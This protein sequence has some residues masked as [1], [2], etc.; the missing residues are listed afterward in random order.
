M[1][2]MIECL[3]A[4]TKAWVQNKQRKIKTKTFR[5]RQSG[6]TWSF[7]KTINYQVI[8]AFCSALLEWSRQHPAPAQGIIFLLHIEERRKVH[9]PY[10][11]KDIFQELCLLLLPLFLICHVVTYKLI[12]QWKIENDWRPF[13][14]TLW[15]LPSQK[16]GCY[17]YVQI[18]LVD[19][20]NEKRL[21]RTVLD[22]EKPINL[23]ILF[24]FT[25]KSILTMK[26]EN[27]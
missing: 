10:P 12:P 1:V 21:Q 16:L 26:N 5:S 3:P 9:N 19:Q 24:T 23:H 14:A 11:P 8:P 13:I 20:I 27:K 4:S 2:Q 17:S 15:P 22:L 6:Q 7:Y 25:T 18:I